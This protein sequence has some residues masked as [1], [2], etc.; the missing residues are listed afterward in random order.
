[1]CWLI[2]TTTIIAWS[3]LD[4]VTADDFKF[5]GTLGFP[6][7]GPGNWSKKHPNLSIATWNTR[8]LTFERFNYCK[9]L[10]HDILAITELWRNS[11]KFTDGTVSFTH[12]APKI[13]VNTGLPSFPDDVAAGVGIL[14][15]ERAQKQYIRHGSPC[16]RL[17]WVRL[18]GP[19]TNLFVIAA[20]IPH[21]ARIKPCQDDT[22]NSLVELLKQ[23]PK[24][25]CVVLAGDF[26]EQLPKNVEQLTGKWAFGSESAN[27]DKVLNV[28]RMFN[29]SAVSTFFQPKKKSS[30]ATYVSCV[31]GSF[32]PKVDKF[33][34]LGVSTF[35]TG[36]RIFG[37]VGKEA[38]IQHGTERMWSVHFEDGY[39]TIANERKLRAWLTPAKRSYKQIDHILVSQRWKS[40]VTSCC[41]D[42]APSIHRS[43]WGQ[44]EDHALVK[45]TW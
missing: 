8:S 6:G 37:K 31:D 21:R 26:N 2:I 23:V 22:L 29:L 28:M 5:N 25:D 41:S 34:G 44:K 7:E 38:Q 17:T 33:E 42:W 11:H 24:N 36:K 16:E 10:G 3:T 35:Y 18:K 43:R 30:S 4:E 45:S 15:S 39:S 40:C 9:N 13:S 32:R 1:M 20:Y 27:A 14:L 12:S 19:V